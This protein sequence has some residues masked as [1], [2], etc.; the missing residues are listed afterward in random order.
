MTR[1]LSQWA[2]ANGFVLP[3]LLRQLDADGRCAYPDPATWRSQWRSRTL[4]AQP[5][6]SCV[7]D[8]EWLDSDAAS[9]TVAEW[10]NPRFQNGR[11]FLPFAQ[12]GAGDAYCLTPAGNGDLGVALVWHDLAESRLT[13]ASFEDFVYES[14]VLSAGDFSHLTEDGFTRE[15]A[16]QCVA[17]NISYLKPFLS[18]R[19]RAGLDALLQGGNPQAPADGMITLE[20]QQTAL[21]VLAEISEAPFSVVARW[22]C[23]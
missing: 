6:L 20:A 1:S 13:A 15:E 4:A 12:T 17:A 23:E 9:E 14:L 16:G 18:E 11:R 22:E 2:D 8:M 21:G 7:Y 5:A 3:P 19:Y 10:L